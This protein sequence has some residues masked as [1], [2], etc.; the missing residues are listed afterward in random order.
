MLV[1]VTVGTPGQPSTMRIVTWW[2]DTQITNGSDYWSSAANGEPCTRASSKKFNSEMLISAIVD[3]TV[4][5]TFHILENTQFNDTLGDISA[6]SV[7]WYSGEYAQDTLNIDGNTFGNFTFAVIESGRELGD[8]M[9]GLGA[10][11]DEAIVQVGGV[12]TTPE[13]TFLTYVVSKGLIQTTAFSIFADNPTENL[14]TGQ[15]LLGG[16]DA[17][18][19]EGGLET[20]STAVATGTKTNTSTY[21]YALS[22]T[23][24]SLSFSPNG[25]LSNQNVL[26]GF[27]PL[28]V[29]PGLPTTMLPP[30][31]VTSFWIALGAT[32]DITI[33]PINAI[34]IVPCAYLLNS[35]TVNF[36]FGSNIIIPVPIS[37]LTIHNGTGFGNA[38][39]PFA[40]ACIL[41]IVAI[42]PT[43]SFSGIGTA[44]I[45]HM[46]TVYDLQNNQISVGTRG[47]SATNVL[48][49]SQAGVSAL[50]LS[51]SSTPTS[52]STPTSG[53]KRSDALAIGL[54]V[55]LSL[56][57]ML[58]IGLI[59]GWFFLRRR[60]Q[61]A[62]AVPTP[63][64]GSAL[65]E[66]G[67]H[68]SQAGIAYGKVSAHA[69]INNT[70]PS[71]SPVTNF[72]DQAPEPFRGTS[73]SPT[74][75]TQAQELLGSTVRYSELSGISAFASPHS[76]ISNTLQSPSH[77]PRPPPYEGT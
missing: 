69:P 14:P 51:A 43:L 49:I 57:L 5:T 58:V 2:G 39:G 55:G 47:G 25:N 38:D 44:V 45:K 62:D 10:N 60:R 6:G 72:H 34:P 56:G 66:H 46:Y 24:E 12:Y 71:I 17:G 74:E 18:K 68:N 29:H 63:M 42:D 8:N 54:G 15:I 19:I 4:S 67:N 40:D 1:N 22:I 35:T 70:V 48:E 3:P 13:N 73:P 9:I 61:R 53:P 50:N 31:V 65:G 36:H 11:A 20:L 76:P 59:A 37:D 52:I 27:Q 26:A 28:L 64:S 21:D 41:D 33:D 77:I 7:P 23:L 32:F 30:D 75:S 16:V